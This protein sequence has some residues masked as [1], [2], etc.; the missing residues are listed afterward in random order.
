[1]EIENRKNLDKIQNKDLNLF[2]IYDETFNYK[3]LI[4]IS[5]FIGFLLSLILLIFQEDEYGLYLLIK[6]LPEESLVSESN[7][8]SNPLT[9]ISFSF[10]DEYYSEAISYKIMKTKETD[11]SKL[12]III[13]EADE[14]SDFVSIYI[15]GSN[16]TDI[17]NYAQNFLNKSNSNISTKIKLILLSNLKNLENYVDNTD[18]LIN[19]LSA[20]LSSLDQNSLYASIVR[21]RSSLYQRQYDAMQA[22]ELYKQMIISSEKSQYTNFVP[23]NHDSE[24]AINNNKIKSYVIILSCLFFGFILGIFISVL[25]ILKTRSI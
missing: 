13:D 3:K 10:L 19:E 8:K 7:I 11:A 14:G 18:K 4:F 5:T 22:I 16:R 2:R 24:L 25:M 23:V 12:G 9:N 20:G 15:S 1:M 21:D 6:N 17:K